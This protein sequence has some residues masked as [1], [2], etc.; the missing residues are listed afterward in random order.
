MKSAETV[1]LK[2]APSTSQFPVTQPVNSLINKP[3]NLVK[4]LLVMTVLEDM[5][6][7]IMLD[8]KRNRETLQ[9]RLVIIIAFTI[10]S[11]PTMV[12]FIR[13]WNMLHGPKSGP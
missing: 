10:G 13:P 8:K 6:D 4:L 7:T 11:V 1:F 2:P 9:C 3:V 5:E 12:R